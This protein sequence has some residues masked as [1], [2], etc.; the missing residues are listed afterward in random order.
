MSASVRFA[1]CLF[2]LVLGPALASAQPPAPLPAPE[3]APT[4]DPPPATTPDPAVTTEPAPEPAATAEADKPPGSIHYDGGFIAESGDDQFELKI[5]IRTQTRLEITRREALDEF[6]SHFVVPRLRLQLEGYAW[7]K[8]NAYKVEFDF[9]NRG[10]PVLKDFFIDHTFAAIAGQDVHVRGG[11]WKKPFARHELVSDYASEF[12]ERALANGLVDI[13][14]DL[15]VMVHNGYDKSPDGLEWALGVF[16]GQGDADRPAATLDCDDP[17]DASTCTVTTP[18][19]TPA[20]LSPVVVARVGWNMGGIKG[21]SEGDLEGG[22][23]RLAVGASYQ[24]NLN[25]FAKDVDGDLLVEHGAEVDAIAKY[26]GIDVQGAA[27]MLKR[28]SADPDYAFFGQAGYFVV[29]KTYQLAARYSLTPAAGDDDV[30][31]ILGAFT[32]FFKGHNFKWATDGGVI[33]TSATDSNDLQIRTQL[34]AAF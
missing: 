2:T 27:Y 7:G 28:G 33:V 6:Q 4:T 10:D 11:Q 5:G 14:R 21:Y 26:E 19:N 16:N 3:P 17:A 18:T 24:A 22:P 8:A 1:V 29:P 25:D 34:Q 13:G 23:F 31:E 30:Q 32:W 9:A 15:G 12:N 20:D